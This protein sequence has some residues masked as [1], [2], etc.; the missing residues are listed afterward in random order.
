MQR[1]RGG[2]KLLQV[3]YGALHL[4]ST[5]IISKPPSVIL[6]PFTVNWSTETKKFD[7]VILQILKENCVFLMAS[8]RVLAHNRC[9]VYLSWMNKSVILG[10]NLGKHSTLKKCMYIT[11]NEIKGK[12]YQICFLD[13]FR[14]IRYNKETWI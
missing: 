3:T 6:C 13:F 10:R 9:S 1:D 2:N 5:Y 12:I 7:H 14:N 11:F 8:R 4:L